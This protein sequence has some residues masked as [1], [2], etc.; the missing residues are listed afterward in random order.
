MLFRS[1]KKI[2]HI[3]PKIIIRKYDQDH[4]TEQPPT[5]KFMYLGMLIDKVADCEAEVTRGI[6]AA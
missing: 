5:T 4:Y 1:G 2:E 6:G 3:T